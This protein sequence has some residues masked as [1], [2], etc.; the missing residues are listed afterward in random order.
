MVEENYERQTEGQMIAW[1]ITG[2]D[3]LRHCAFVSHSYTPSGPGKNRQLGKTQP[4]LMH[5]KTKL[6]E[7]EISLR[8]GKIRCLQN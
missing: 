3:G 1:I 6:S 5:E 8:R 2:L 7:S 4:P